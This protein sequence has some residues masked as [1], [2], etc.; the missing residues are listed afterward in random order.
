LDSRR[1]SEREHR[2]LPS[3][4]SD[5]QRGSPARH[6]V[7]RLI[8]APPGYVGYEEGGQ[9][10]ERVRRKPYSVILLDEFEKAHLDVQNV[11]LQ[12]LEDGRLTDGKGR[13]VDFTNTIIIATS[14]VGSDLIHENLRAPPERQKD[15]AQLKNELMNVLRRHLR[16]EFLNRIDEII[17]FHALD[18]DEIRQIV[19]LQLERVKRTAHGQGLTLEFDGSLVDHLAE[20]GYQPEYGARELRRQIRSLVETELASA[21]LRGG[22][23]AGDAVRFSYDKDADE[24]R[25]EKRPAAAP[26]AGAAAPDRSRRAAKGGEPAAERSDRPGTPKP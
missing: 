12:V 21:M 9:L 6:T 23:S 20:I 16:P 18:R 22:V 25:W 7:A 11:L 8:G 14:N 19:L 2:R 1:R 3:K 5:P 26:A 15:Y 13:V 4:T 17:V 10:T 24:V